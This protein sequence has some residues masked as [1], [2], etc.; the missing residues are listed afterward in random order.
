MTREDFKKYCETI[1]KFTHELLKKTEWIPVSEGLSKESGK[2]LVSVI[3][4]ED[5]HP[6]PYVMTAFYAS[7]RDYYKSGWWKSLKDHEKVIAWMQAPEPYDEKG[8]YKE[9][10]E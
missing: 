9:S 5:R 10:K 3:D 7:E 2:Y 8:F 1:S 4:Q 6:Y